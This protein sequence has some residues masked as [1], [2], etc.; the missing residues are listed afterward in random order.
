M[1]CVNGS[2]E[3][4]ATA[5]SPLPQPIDQ[6]PAINGSLSAAGEEVRMED[7]CGS[8]AAAPNGVHFN[9]FNVSRVKKVKLEEA[10]ECGWGVLWVEYE[11]R[12][13]TQVQ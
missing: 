2:H 12:N 11:T 4:A 10:G 5:P 13:G 6:S 9:G 3:V 1:S 7:K 8:P